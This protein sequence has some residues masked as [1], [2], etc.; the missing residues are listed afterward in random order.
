MLYVEALHLELVGLTMQLLY[1]SGGRGGGEFASRLT[2]FGRLLLLLGLLQ[3]RLLVVA[4]ARA[5][6]GEGGDLGDKL[7]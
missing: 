7:L 3:L 1:G 5:F 6:V 2:L 4:D